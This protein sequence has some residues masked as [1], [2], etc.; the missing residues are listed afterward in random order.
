M[1][2]INTLKVNELSDELLINE[3]GE[4]RRIFVNVLVRIES[5][6]AFSDIPKEY[7]LGAGH[8]KFF[9]NKC[10]YIYFRYLELRYE[11]EKRNKKPYSLEHLEVTE[12]MYNQIKEHDCDL[13]NDW[14]PSEQDIWHCKMRIIQRSKNYKRAH[15]Y[16][17]NKIVDW[18]K[19]LNVPEYPDYSHML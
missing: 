19:F 18:H 2:R 9:Y 14:S 1:T 12:S 15:H 5:N 7:T 13:C 16:R 10:F 4:I 11:H 3:L 6:K 17:K 8:M